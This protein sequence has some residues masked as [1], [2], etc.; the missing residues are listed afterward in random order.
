MK[1]LEKETREQ[2]RQLTD[3]ELQILADHW[4]GRDWESEHERRQ[5]LFRARVFRAELK[6]RRATQ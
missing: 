6:K 3:S 1:E 4:E 2:A 5:Q